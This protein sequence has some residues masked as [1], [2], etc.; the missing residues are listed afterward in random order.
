M[1]RVRK[2]H[3]ATNIWLCLNHS[4]KDKQNIDWKYNMPH[5]NDLAAWMILSD[6]TLCTFFSTCTMYRVRKGHPAT[7]IWPCFNHWLVKNLPT[8]KCVMQICHIHAI[9]DDIQPSSLNNGLFLFNTQ[10]W[11]DSMW[12]IVITGPLLLS[13][14]SYESTTLAAIW[15]W[16]N[17]TFNKHEA[18]PIWSAE[19]MLNVDYL[20]DLRT[21]IVKIICTSMKLN[22]YNRLSNYNDVYWTNKPLHKSLR[23]QRPQRKI[24]PPTHITLR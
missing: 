21:V 22:R 16:D 5:T 3:S 23:T 8:Y 20:N 15:L 13:S 19:H 12:H 4:L 9:I 14:A 1:Y 7:N 6:E 2:D 10:G 17:R 11:I 24:L 18:Q